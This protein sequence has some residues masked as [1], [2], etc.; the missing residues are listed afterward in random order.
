MPTINPLTNSAYSVSQSSS[1]SQQGGNSIMGQD[2][3]LKMLVVQMSYQD[4]MNPMDSQQ[5]ASQLAQF[6]SVEQL[7]SINENLE[8]SLSAQLML[9]Q[10]I[11]N[12]MAAGLIGNEA[13]ALNTI[14]NLEDDAASPIQYELAG[15]AD[16]VQLEIYDSDGNLVYSEI[17]GA[18]LAGEHEFQWNGNNSTGASMPDDTYT[19]SVTAETNS[20]YNIAVEQFIEG[21][22]TGVNYEL[23]QALLTIG[24]VQV[25]LADVME[26][27]MPSEG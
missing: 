25:S 1:S 3:F 13:K 4:P 14:V 2:Q 16:S 11:S 17:L 6:T 7:L 21:L 24:N 5:F 19:F 12:T 22:I 26:L 15:N 18:Q 10:S 20:G 8:A 23:G 9:N 27:N